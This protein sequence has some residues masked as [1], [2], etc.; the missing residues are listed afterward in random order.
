MADL[1]RTSDPGIYKRTTSRGETR[2]VVTYWVGGKQRQATRR[3]LKEARA[4]KRS[5]ETDRDPGELFEGSHRPF[6]EYAE[7]WVDSYHGNGRRGLTEHTRE[8]YRRDLNRYAYPFLS[9]RLGRS[10]SSL[11]RAD[12]R[13]WASWLCDEKEQGK[14]LA[15]ATVRRVMAPV[16]ACLSTRRRRW[17]NSGQPG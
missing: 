16:R 11:A 5:R 12:M 10:L 6:R 8:E 4:L 15:D 2:Y 17:P 1:D 3:T 7:E 14:R 9:A 13:A